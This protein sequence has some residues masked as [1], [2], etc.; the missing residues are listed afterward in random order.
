M[1]AT[2]SDLGEW[3]LYVDKKYGGAL[4]TPDFLRE[5]GNFRITLDT[6][7]DETLCPFSEEY[8]NQQLSVYEEISGRRLNQSDGELHP[9]NIPSLLH[10]A[11][12]LGI[13]NVSHASEL[14][15]ALTALLSISQLGVGAKV[16]DM[17][18]GHGLSSEL[19]SFCGANIH[20]IDIDPALSELSRLRSQRLG[21]PIKRSMMNFDDSA[22]L[23]NKHYD[24]A[25][26]FQSLHHCIRPWQLISILK[27]KIVDGGVIGF[28][29]EPIQKSWW[30]HWG[31]R[32]DYESVYV[33]RKY[34]WFESGW[35]HKF[36]RDCFERNS[37]K[38]KF[39]SGGHG[40]GEI[41]IA[42]A[43][44]NRLAA[45]AGRA[46]A[47]G[48]AEVM[49]SG[50][51]SQPSEHYQTQI[52][53]AAELCGRTAFRTSVPRRNGSY[54]CFGPYA[55][56]EPGHYSVSL[57]LE[58]SDGHDAATPESRA[59]FDVVRNWERNI[60]LQKESYSVEKNKLLLIEKNFTI[61]SELQNME[62]RL[63]IIG[64]DTWTCTYPHFRKL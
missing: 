56:L 61:D 21:Y 54:L 17:G 63:E 33:A 16:L 13:R 39:F 29:G 4:G 8:F 59:V 47:L 49:R 14:A 58:R 12:P 2:R 62:A 10:A 60:I 38:L 11:N 43:D 51:E 5:F 18:A 24:A 25:Y 9:V 31:I 44:E 19:F 1:S 32:L 37:M 55:T 15:R 35:S 48:H 40:G 36:I 20:A 64:P 45:I 23:E 7:V 22:I 41:A 30:K 3:V 27:E 28:T 50:N 42:S 53:E 52:G 6:K 26:F 46:R 57:L 34:G